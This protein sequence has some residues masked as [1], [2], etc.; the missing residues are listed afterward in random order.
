[1]SDDP[2][3]KWSAI[4]EW[5][6]EF[7]L[8][9]GREPIVWLDKCCLNQECIAD[10]LACLPVFLAGCNSLVLFVGKTYLHR[11]WY[12]AEEE[13]ESGHNSASEANFDEVELLLNIAQFDAREAREEE[14]AEQCW[15]YL[16][17]RSMSRRQ[18]LGRRHK[19]GSKN[20]NA[21]AARQAREAAVV[22][23]YAPSELEAEDVGVPHVVDLVLDEVVVN[24]ALAAKRVLSAASSKKSYGAKKAREATTAHAAHAA[25]TG[26]R[27]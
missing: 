18:G 11:L 5:R 27:A 16:R 26:A 20:F 19:G 23:K 9:H 22:S 15:L 3:A 1:W 21:V 2:G 12:P 6:H 7:R 10:H 17:T 24:E 8:A 13:D 14:L 4:C 25:R